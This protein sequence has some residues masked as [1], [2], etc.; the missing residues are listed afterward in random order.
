M[1]EIIDDTQTPQKR[2]T[3]HPSTPH[4]QHKTE[5]NAMTR[6]APPQCILQQE[7]EI[8]SKDTNHTV[9]LNI[10]CTDAPT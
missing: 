6:T 5:V 3:Q 2:P 8:P 10:T 7:T 1:Q 9:S 4:S